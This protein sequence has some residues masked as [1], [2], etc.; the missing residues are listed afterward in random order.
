M[1]NSALIAAM[2][3]YLSGS[4][5]YASPPRMAT[6]L[7]RAA[8]SV[9]ADK[10]AFGV[11]TAPLIWKHGEQLHGFQAA[12]RSPIPERWQ[13]ILQPL[14]KGRK[15]LIHSRAMACVAREVAR[16]VNRFETGP[17]IH[18]TEQLA[19]RCGTVSPWLRPN[20]FK[21]KISISAI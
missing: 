1:R 4:G 3:A 20:T 21:P 15:G 5:A 17:A 8:T 7:A 18:L 16:F 9:R 12:S 14:L 11:G 10:G 19:R 13:P 6:D 2:T